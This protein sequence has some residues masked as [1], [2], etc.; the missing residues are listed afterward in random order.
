MAGPPHQSKQVIALGGVWGSDLAGM[1]VAE[2]EA[3]HLPAA[4]TDF[5]YCLIGERW[6]IAGTSGVLLAYFVLI[7]GI[8]RVA[9]KTEEPFGRLV[10][11]G[12]AAWLGSQA[13]INTGMTVGLVPITG[14]TL[15]LVSY[16]GSSMVATGLAIGLVVSVAVR[17][18]FEVR[19]PFSRGMGE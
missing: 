17:P 7:A 18:G 9:G 15:P 3:Y 8:L 13:V 4:R 1:P 5:I 14:I 16:G 12:V 10:C 19:T 2:L 6:G 11:V